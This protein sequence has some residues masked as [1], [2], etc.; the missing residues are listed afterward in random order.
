VLPTS[1]AP[2]STAYRHRYAVGAA[3]KP[4]LIAL[5]P[6]SPGDILDGATKLVRRGAGTVVGLSALLNALA[7]VPTVLL[8][9]GF[10]T[11]SWY[12][13]SGLSRVIDART[14]VG[15]V[16]SGGTVLA[17]VA[18][19]GLLAPVA[20]EAILGRR[21]S[22]AQ[23]WAAARPILLRVLGATL[24]VTVVAVGPWLALVVGLALLARAPVPVV[25]IVG[26]LLT[27]A[28]VASTA[29][30]LPRL[31]FVGPVVALERVGLREGLARAIELSRKRFWPILGV[32]LLALGVAALVFLF[33]ELVGVIVGGIAIDL[34][35][36]TRAQ[37]STAAGFVVPFSTLVAATLVSPFLATCVILQYVDARMRKEG[38]DLVLLRGT[39]TRAGGGS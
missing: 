38:L 24:A 13:R 10:E 21:I 19:T 14:M 26:F 22:L 27:I 25:L 5:K 4:G 36:L 34:L 6:Q 12:Y 7:V 17:T 15:L 3:H 11:G 8:V 16:L 9:L 31:V 29:A 18:L 33:L 1:A 39:S 20:G 28:A 2:G 23:A 32:S 35:D 37:T 30:V